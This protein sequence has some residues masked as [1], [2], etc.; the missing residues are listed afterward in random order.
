MLVFHHLNSS[1]LPIFDDLF[2]PFK[3]QQFFEEN[4]EPWVKSSRVRTAAY[5]IREK[6][7]KF[8]YPE[9]IQI[10]TLIPMVTRIR[11]KTIWCEWIFDSKCSWIKGWWNSGKTCA[12]KGKTIPQEERPQSINSSVRA[13]PN[14]ELKNSRFWGLKNETLTTTDVQLSGPTHF[15]SRRP[16]VNVHFHFPLN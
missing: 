14:L 2:K 3:E 5:A 4:D 11:I 8:L 9:K 16:F 1:L 12:K 10:L 6:L 7:K 15:F 13:H